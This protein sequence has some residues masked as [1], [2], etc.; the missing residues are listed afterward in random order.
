VIRDYLGKTSLSNLQS[1]LYADLKMIWSDI[2]KVNEE[3]DKTKEGGKM[4][5]KRCFHNVFMRLATR[6]Y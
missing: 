6:L 5:G 4:N 2:S 3:M 1:T